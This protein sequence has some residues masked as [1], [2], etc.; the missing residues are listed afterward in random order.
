KPGSGF[1]LNLDSPAKLPFGELIE[2]EIKE[3]VSKYQIDDII[4]SAVD[5]GAL[6]YCIKART[7]TAIKRALGKD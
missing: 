3:I 4:I 6:G 7:E 5:K 2:N 1:V